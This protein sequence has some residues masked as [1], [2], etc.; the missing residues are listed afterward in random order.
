MLCDLRVGLYTGM[1]FE[2][3]TF[4]IGARGFRVEGP[5][6]WGSVSGS[7]LG[8]SEMGRISGSAIRVQACQ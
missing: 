2:V 6:A 4:D 8:M 3:L 1:E 7:A 5:R